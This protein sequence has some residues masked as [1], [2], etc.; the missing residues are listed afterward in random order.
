MD[1]R[2]C[3]RWPDWLAWRGRVSKQVSEYLSGGG[4][5]WADYDPETRANPLSC[6]RSQSLVFSSSIFPTP[7][8]NALAQ[9]VTNCITRM[10]NSTSHIRSNSREYF[11]SVTALRFNAKSVPHLPRIFSI[12]S[13]FSHCY[14]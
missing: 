1:E 13:S 11:R 6:L 14:E 9:P 4:E 3:R 8:F 10:K 7:N 2:E 5:A 12:S